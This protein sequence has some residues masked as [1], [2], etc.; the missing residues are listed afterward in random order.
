MDNET[1]RE[2]FARAVEASAASAMPLPPWAA[3]IATCY[4]GSRAIAA[5]MTMCSK[6]SATP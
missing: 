2:L 4:A 6:I 1:Q 5:C 3:P